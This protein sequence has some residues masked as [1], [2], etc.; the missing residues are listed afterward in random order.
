M[1][2]TLISVAVLSIMTAPLSITSA[3][4]QHSSTSLY[5]ALDNGIRWSNKV[6][7]DYLGNAKQSRLGMN[8]GGL[9]GSH[10]GFKGQEDLGQGALT[11]FKLEAG[12]NL[13]TGELN[14]SSDSKIYGKKTESKSLFGRQAYLGL[15]HQAL[16]Y[17]TMGRQHTVSYDAIKDFDPSNNISQHQAIHYLSGYADLK[18]NHNRSDATIKY[19]HQLGQVT[20]LASYKPGN[21]VGS[22]THGAE[23]ATGLKYKNANWGLGASFT[24][25]GLA[26]MQDTTH[27]HSQA[28]GKTRIIN[29]AGEYKLDRLKLKAGISRS[30]IPAMTSGAVLR[31]PQLMIPHKDQVASFL[32]V[33]AWGVQ[34]D[35]THKVAL[36]LSHYAQWHQQRQSDVLLGKDKRTVMSA[37]YQ[38]SKRT[39]LYSLLEW[40]SNRAGVSEHNKSK[41]Q[42][43]VTAG[44]RHR[45]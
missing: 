2:K 39:D 41:N 9:S 24:E 25:I 37:V 4:T 12:I 13:N 36:N 33:A 1:K 21:Q 20:T 38:L 17:L 34:Y 32:T 40:R 14:S 42:Q 18:N 26:K 27:A 45:F 7:Q 30:S 5:G 43:S 3:Q 19:T 22:V 10:L 15:G 28:L 6:G 11:F 44:L 35:L 16:G 31:H 29:L 8:T 23:F